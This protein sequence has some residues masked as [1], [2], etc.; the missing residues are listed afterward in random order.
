MRVEKVKFWK[1]EALRRD[2]RGKHGL[3]SEG[4]CRSARELRVTQ[5]RRELSH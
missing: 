1:W 5:R 4:S 3:D 2:C